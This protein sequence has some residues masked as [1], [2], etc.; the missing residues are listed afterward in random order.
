MKPIALVAIAAATALPAAQQGRFS[1]RVDIV[2]VDALVTAGG[3]PVR[4][5]GAA[6]FEVRDDGVLQQVDLVNTDEMP[7]NAILTLDMSGS[8]EGDRLAHLR[9]AGRALLNALGKDDRAA[10]VSFSH[11]IALGSKLTTDHA[12]VRDALDLAQPSGNT[13]LID[14]SY[15]GLILGESDAGRALMIAFSDGVDTASWLTPEQV[16]DTG[17]RSDAVVYGVSVTGPVKV[18]FLRDLAALTG[19]SL[20]EIESTKDLGALFLKV[21]DEFR[22]RYLLSFTP[23]GVS[24]QGYHHLEVGVK[25]RDV[26]VKA[27]PGYLAGG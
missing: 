15:A 10:L 22:H 19:G 14:A 21:L 23:R 9:A 18:T 3:K 16:L 27:R 17:R 2:R 5:L 7:V 6:D 25:G 12:R 26:K 4:G 13:S 11:L 20:F 24:K 1:A 8:V